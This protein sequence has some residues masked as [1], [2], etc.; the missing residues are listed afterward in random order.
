MRVPTAAVG[1]GLRFSQRTWPDAARPQSSGCGG[2]KAC[3]T[4]VSGLRGGRRDSRLE[5][6]GTSAEGLGC[7][8][9]RA[10]VNLSVRLRLEAHGAD[11]PD[12]KLLPLMMTLFDA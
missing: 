11:T 8:A 7:L 12:G 6:V 3:Q 4:S 1:T 10:V 2:R 9:E 5:G